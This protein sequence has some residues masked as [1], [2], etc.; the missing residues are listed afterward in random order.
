MS[1]ISIDN[2]EPTCAQL[3]LWSNREMSRCHVRMLWLAG[4]CK[5]QAKRVGLHVGL[6]ISN[7]SLVVTDRASASTSGRKLASRGHESAER[8]HCQT[9]DLGMRVKI[10]A[11]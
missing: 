9:A 10:I 6:V 5:E 1:I 2:Y 4:Q 8:R 7:P 11:V 3:F